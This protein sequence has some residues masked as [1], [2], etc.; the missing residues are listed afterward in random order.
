MGQWN[1]AYMMFSIYKIEDDDVALLQLS[2]A[3]DC[4]R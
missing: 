4:S 2:K 1:E 3:R